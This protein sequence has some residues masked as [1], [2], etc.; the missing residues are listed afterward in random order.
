MD[1]ARR[2]TIH[3]VAAEAGVSL[4]TVSH[5]LNGK[6]RMEADTRERVQAV[7]TRLG[8]HPNRAARGLASGRTFT[9]GLS[10]PQI[11]SLTMGEHFAGDW[12]RQMATRASY[13]AVEHAHAMTILP[14]FSTVEEV[15]RFPVD[16]M[17]VLDP[18]DR[19]PRLRL[20]KRARIPYVTIGW[21][22]S[23][24]RDLHVRPD[25]RTGM[26][27][28]LAH[29]AEQGARSVLLLAPP[30][31]IDSYGDSSAASAAWSAAS[32]IPVTF[33]VIGE[34]GSQQLADL[35]AAAGSAAASA[36]TSGRPPDAIIGLMEGFGRGILAGAASVGRAAPA[37]VLV[38][39]DI[40]GE[41][42]SGSRPPITALDLHPA[43][44]AVAGVDLLL[45]L[46]AG[47]KPT[48]VLIDISLR[49]RESTLRA[50]TVA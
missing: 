25:T 18:V 16:G 22:R 4:T 33:Q 23:Q 30:W 26:T 24:P 29:L 9:L 49:I 17:L 40:D 8:Y 32:G 21:D 20:L 3:D 19:E 46:L 44:Q 43:R 37:D 41:S 10:M 13:A 50:E 38:A 2:P 35:V 27:A 36:L 14:Y 42:T 39:E 1:R 31:D 34:L 12:Y 47:E 7:A 15:S 5:A 45:A 11:A 48:S 6:G 28:L